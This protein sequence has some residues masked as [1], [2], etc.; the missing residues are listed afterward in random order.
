[1][2]KPSY[3]KRIS[4]NQLSFANDEDYIFFSD[5]DEIPNPEI[6]Y[7]FDLNKKYGI[8]MQKCFNYKFNLFNSFET[9]WEGSRVCKKKI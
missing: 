4:I 2:E 1:M 9:P 3:P 5:P 8:F 6:L 7:N